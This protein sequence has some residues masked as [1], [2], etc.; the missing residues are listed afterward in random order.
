IHNAQIAVDMDS[1]IIVENHTEDSVSD[2]AAAEPALKNRETSIG[3]PGKL[4]GDGGYGNMQ[5]IESCESRGVEPVCAT[6]R[7]E[8]SAPPN[9]AEALNA[10]TYDGTMNQFTCPH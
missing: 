8:R 4:V 1:Q 7:Q 10:F 9:G 2:A 6:R 5:T 3:V